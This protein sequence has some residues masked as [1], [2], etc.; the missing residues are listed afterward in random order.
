V[1]ED[2]RKGLLRAAEILREARDDFRQPCNG[3]Q[4]QLICASTAATLNDLL[5]D[6]EREVEED[7]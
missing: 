4:F 6:I 3:A 2:Y 1:S 5:E 7:R